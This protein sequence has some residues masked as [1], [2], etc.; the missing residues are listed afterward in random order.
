MRNYLK[1][2]AFI[3]AATIVI[4]AHPKPQDA[5]GSSIDSGGNYYISKVIYLS[6][7]KYCSIIFDIYVIRVR[8]YAPKSKFGGKNKP[9]NEG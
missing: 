9:I 7:N 6:T 1:I 3:L 5:E 8:D 4:K 2:N